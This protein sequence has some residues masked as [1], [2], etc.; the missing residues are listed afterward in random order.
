MIP[1]FCASTSSVTAFLHSENKET[2]PMAYVK[3]RIATAATAALVLGISGAAVAGDSGRSTEL[4]PQAD[5][6]LKKMSDYMGGLKSFAADAYVVDEQIMGDGFKL[7]VLKAGS[8]KVQRPNKFFIAHKSTVGEQEAFFDG[9]HLIVHGKGIGKFIKVPVSGDVDAALD[10]VTETL[11]AEL[12]A[13]DLLSSDAYTPLME[14]VEESAH[15]GAVEIGGVTCRHLAFRTDEVD[16][17]LWIEEGRRPLPC[18][19]TITSRWVYAAPQYS[20]TLTNWRVNPGFSAN[21][22]KFTAPDGTKS[23]T[24]EKFRESLEQAGGE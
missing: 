2:K 15:L 6:L 4:D 12:P 14:P 10:A 16:W 11:G 7:S 23:T 19:Y 8:I 9:S 13:R 22:F 17:Q 1:T 3:R 5:A 21:D 20:V 24:V 18:R